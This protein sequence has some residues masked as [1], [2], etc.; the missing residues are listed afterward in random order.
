M[1]LEFL[2]FLDNQVSVCVIIHVDHSSDS[3]NTNI[4]L[5]LLKMLLAVP[6]LDPWHFTWTLVVGQP[7]LQGFRGEAGPPGPK[8]KL[9]GHYS[10]LA[11]LVNFIY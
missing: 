8:G 7:G 2:G 11:D 4:I 5:N 9:Q 10:E 6:W 1:H 3:R